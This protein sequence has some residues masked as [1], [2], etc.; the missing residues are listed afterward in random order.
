MRRKDGLADL[1][2]SVI[3]WAAGAGCGC[4]PNGDSNSA[5][6][7]QFG[8]PASISS[9]RSMARARHYATTSIVAALDVALGSPLATAMRAQ[10]NNPR[11]DGNK[12]A[13]LELSPQKLARI[14]AAIGRE[15]TAFRAL[16]QPDGFRMQNARQVLLAEFTTSGVT[17]RAGSKEWVMAFSGYGYGETLGAPSTTVPVAQANSVEYRRGNLTEWY[18]NGPLGLEQGFTLTDAPDRLTTTGTALLSCGSLPPHAS[19]AVSPTSL[20]LSG[21]TGTAVVTINLENKGTYT[22]TFLGNYSSLV[23]TASATLTVK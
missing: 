3:S 14:S 15:E 17:L 19:C 2:R 6:Q 23:Q 20:N 5:T 1:A 8:S 13:S 4:Q 16:A 7:K 22:L 18:V 10:L 9:V 11:R 21:S 12:L